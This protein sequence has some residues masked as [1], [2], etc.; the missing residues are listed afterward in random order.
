MAPEEIEL[1][2]T[3]P[4]EAAINGSPGVRRIRSI[5]ADGIA[6]LWVEFEWGANIYHARQVVAER[7]HRV[8]LPEQV[9][10]PELGP[11]SSI[12]GEITFVA[13]TSETVSAMEL[14]R[15]AETIVRRNLLAISGISQVIPIGGEI[16]QLQVTVHPTAL[17]QQGVPLAEVSDAIRRA[18]RSPAAGFHVE[19]G[20]EYL[21]RGLG[22]ARG[23][24]EIAETM[25]RVTDGV[26]V[27]VGELARVDWGP[28]PARGTASYRNRPAVVLSVQKQP[29]ANTLEV[30]REIDATLARL[31][32]SLP[33]GV[34]LE[35][36]SFRQADFIAVAIDRQRHDGVEGWG[37]P[38]DRHPRPLSRQFAHD[39][40][41]GAGDPAVAGGGGSRPLGLRSD[42]QYD[43][44]SVAS[45]SPS[46][47]WWTMP[48]SWWK[49]SSDDCERSVWDRSPSGARRRKWSRR[50]RPRS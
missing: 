19:G 37:H 17:A 33:E 31:D 14:R 1:L 30:T 32:R 42:D 48:S 38:G 4:V 28:E 41:F 35:T 49:T 27:R 44:S 9:E 18:S 43:E 10:S 46:V 8:E 29:D 16:R 5:S 23:P 12:M 2:V 47:F 26:P 7:L 36:E 25:V 22:R 3:L 6:V 11:I 20:R 21:V 13:L 50:R 40:H 34:V 45:P 15:L 24:G 39:T